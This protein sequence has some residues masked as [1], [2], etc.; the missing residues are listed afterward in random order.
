MEPVAN[1]MIEIMPVDQVV[2]RLL[3]HPARMHR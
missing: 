2:D 3:S 1:Q